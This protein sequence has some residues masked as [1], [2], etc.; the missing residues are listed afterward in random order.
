MYKIQKAFIPNTEHSQEA[1]VETLKLIT[2]KDLKKGK[3]QNPESPVHDF[4]Q[5]SS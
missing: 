5:G 4:T 2:S 3:Y 1:N